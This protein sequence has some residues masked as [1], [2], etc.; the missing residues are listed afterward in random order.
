MEGG[1][2]MNLENEL[3]T[4][5][6]L[7]KEVSPQILRIYG[8][9]VEVEIKEDETEVTI[10]DHLA[11]QIIVDGLVA[12][13]PDDGI[14]SE[15]LNSLEGSNNRVWYIDPIDGTTGFIK[16]RGDFAIH[17]GLVINEEPVLGVV[18][19]PTM[20]ELYFAIKGQGAFHECN[21]ERT[22]LQVNDFTHQPVIVLGHNYRSMEDY[23]EAINW[24]S[25]DSVI[26]SGSEGLRMMHVAQGDADAHLLL[27]HRAGTW[28]TCA[29][30]IIAEEAGA[31][32]RFLD[33][34]PLTYHGQRSW[35]GK[36][37]ILASSEK[38]YDKLVKQLSNVGREY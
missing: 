28:D 6:N 34:T 36:S 1:C 17:I 11:N 38:L 14:V 2:I 29:P 5:I 15:E 25:N 30:Q 10:A 19:H 8:E 21:G 7:A 31:Y 24:V 16:Q 37:L 27:N 9:S 18:Y 13:F 12:A 23:A 26:E 4:A 32:I 20:I 3:N 33:G 35:N 22:P